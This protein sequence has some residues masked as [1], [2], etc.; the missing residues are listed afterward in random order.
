MR[1]IFLGSIILLAAG[2]AAA[3]EKVDVCVYGGT[4]GGVAAAVTVSKQGKSV[5][6]IEPGR[7]LGGMSS[8]GLGQT[9]FGNKQVIGGLSKQ[10]YK[11][12]GKFYGQEEGWQFQPHHAEAVFEEWVKE[13]K[14]RVVREERLKSV[15]KEGKRILAIALEKAP[16]DEMNA[17]VANASGDGLEIEAKVFIDATYEGDLMAK[18]GVSYAVG[19]ESSAQY[20]EPLNGIRARTPLHQF[21]VR[22]DP[23]VRPGDPESGLIPLIQ[24][25][26]GGRPGDGDRRVQVYNFRMCLTRD[27]KNKI[28]ITPPSGYEERTYELLARLLEANTATKKKVTV[29]QLMKLDLLPGGKTDINNN[30]AVSTDYIGMNYDYPDGDW[31]TRGRIWRDHVNY[32]RGF[33]FFLATSPRV[34]EEIQ[35]TGHPPD[36]SAT[37]PEANYLKFIFMQFS[38]S[39]SATAR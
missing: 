38:N 12:V 6:L 19:R 36:R 32:T 27:P 29:G 1:S 3:A 30:G 22:V 17:Q 20:G 25:G 21:L 11:R 8:G 28:P 10:F 34:P 39:S 5:I 13:N 2:V 26:D 33:F 15:R 16:T 24:T 37:F 23:Y 9:D 7:H 4:A 14:V 18:A 31:A 35:A